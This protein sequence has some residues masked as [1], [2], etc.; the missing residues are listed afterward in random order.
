[1]LDV[2][3]KIVLID[4]ELFNTEANEES[5]EWGQ[6]QF[7]GSQAVPRLEMPELW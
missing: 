1:M 2:N 5:H 7:S 6:A 4:L 3:K